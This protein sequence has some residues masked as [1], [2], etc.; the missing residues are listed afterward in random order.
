MNEEYMKYLSLQE[1]SKKIHIFLFV[2]SLSI[3]SFVILFSI[4]TFFF[5]KKIIFKKMC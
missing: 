1:S 4:K 5:E 2:L 3:Y